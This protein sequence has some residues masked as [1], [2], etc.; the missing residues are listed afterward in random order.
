MIKQKY[1]TDN[2]FLQTKEYNEIRNTGSNM[3]NVGESYIQE[4]LNASGL[5]GYD[6]LVIENPK[7]T[8]IMN[9]NGYLDFSAVYPVFAFTVPYIK[10]NYT[11]TSGTSIEQEFYN[12]RIQKE[13]FTVSF[14]GV[15]EQN[16]EDKLS[17]YKIKTQNL[18]IN[19]STDDTYQAFAISS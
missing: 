5:V 14:T 17:V 13:N 16:I 1:Y 18:Y 11:D 15:L 19:I 7:I 6:S 4:R 2:E 12:V 10:V 8:S 9:T 3:N